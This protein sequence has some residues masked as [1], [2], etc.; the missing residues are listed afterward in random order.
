MPGYEL[1]EEASDD[2]TSI[3]EYTVDE[4]GRNQAR[5]YLDSLIETFEILASRPNLGTDCSHFLRGARRFN[6]RSHVI[7]YRA[8]DQD[9][10]I[11]RVLGR[12]QDPVR[13]L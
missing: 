8:R 4:F 11:L 10:L 12:D 9:L 7:Y 1:S 2:V 6:H 13:H 3:L 5:V